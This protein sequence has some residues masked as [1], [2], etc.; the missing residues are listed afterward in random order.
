M[1]FNDAAGTACLAFPSTCWDDSLVTVL[2]SSCFPPPFG[3][4]IFVSLCYWSCCHLW[5][6]AVTPAATE[7]RRRSI[8]S[9]NATQYL[10]AVA[11]CFRLLCWCVMRIQSRLALVTS[12]RQSPRLAFWGPCHEN[13]TAFRGCQWDS[14]S[15]FWKEKRVWKLAHRL[16]GSIISSYVQLSRIV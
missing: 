8:V 9:C 7:T 12:Q 3:N 11:S 2:F 16:S 10:L 1:W 15:K 6:K 5:L 13:S 4:V 14:P